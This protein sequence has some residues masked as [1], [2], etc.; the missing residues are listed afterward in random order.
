VTLRLWVDTDVGDDPDDAVA[1]WCAAHHPDVEFVG[2]STVDGDVEWRAREAR[3]VLE[4][5][6]L[7]DTKV[8]EGA[9]PEDLG[10]A[11]AFLGIGPWTHAPR[12]C[13]PDRV[14]LMGGALGS[15]THHGR[16]VRLEH[17]VGRDPSAA[18]R[19]VAGERRLRI[20]PLD[21]TVATACTA[22]E[23]AAL[24]A[25]IPGLDAWLRRWRR[26]HRDQRAFVLHDP[27]ALLALCEEPGIR[28]ETRRV[29]VEESGEMR[30]VEAGSA[31]GTEH[32]V[33]VAVDRDTVVARV[34][35]LVG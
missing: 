31:D 21:A 35:A 17:N 8:V 27:L 34:L 12:V 22:E 3:A 26:W 16:T 33:V 23:E 18:A 6:G 2:V 14:A 9:P 32:E 5:A 29:A 4:A 11:D 30:V 24:V 7:P 13:L 15:V 25:A 1:L 20:V 28:I 19:V 10:G